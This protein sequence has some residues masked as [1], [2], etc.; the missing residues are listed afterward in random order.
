MALTSV[1]PL[2]SRTPQLTEVLF[3]SN[4]TTSSRW[5]QETGR[6]ADIAGCGFIEDGEWSVTCNIRRIGRGTTAYFARSGDGGA[7]VWAGFMVCTEDPMEYELLNDDESPILK[8]DGTIATG[9]Y[10]QGR[11]HGWDE[12]LWVPAADIQAEGWPAT[13]A[14]FGSKAV[15][16]FRNGERMTP[17]LTR[18]LTEAVAPSLRRDIYLEIKDVTGTLPWWA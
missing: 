11:L 17:D 10:V 1:P 7:P 3:G 5:S 16:Q 8:A 15:P 12:R 4:H 2:G 13:R 9:W 6:T 14:P 18:A